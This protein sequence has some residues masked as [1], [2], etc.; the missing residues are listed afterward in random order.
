MNSHDFVLERKQR[1]GPQTLA[2]GYKSPSPCP[3]ANI[4]TTTTTTTTK[5]AKVCFLANFTVEATADPDTQ[6]HSLKMAVNVSVTVTLNLPLQTVATI[7]A[8]DRAE[9]KSEVVD[10]IAS[11][12]TTAVIAAVKA[13][14]Y[15]IKP[16]STP[17]SNTVNTTGFSVWVKNFF[18]K[19][20]NVNN[21]TGDTK[22]S[23]L[24]GRIQDQSGI[25][26][27][28][29]VFVF[30]GKQLWCGHDYHDSPDR[31]LDEVRR[32]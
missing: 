10:Q 31:S 4:L 9:L 8:S 15:D 21:L 29:M 26:P 2:A 5:N 18:S 7:H 32:A 28:Q 1:C 17:V 20:M 30:A 6:Q 3:A 27:D 19:T 24:A 11:K 13:L 12:S 22:M 16:K 25:P 23:E 14:P